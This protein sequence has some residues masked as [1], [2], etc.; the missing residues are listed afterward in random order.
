MLAETQQEEVLGPASVKV[1]RLNFILSDPAYRELQQLASA[2]HQSMTE[3]VRYGIGIM[4]IAT[5]AR[6][7]KHKLMVVDQ[8]NKAVKEIVMP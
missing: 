3:V 7:N 1:K 2:N 5:E 6:H 4:K 8:S